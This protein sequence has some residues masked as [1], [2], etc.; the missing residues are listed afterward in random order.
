M[1]KDVEVSMSFKG[2]TV[3]TTLAAIE[4][5]NEKLMATRTGMARIE[6]ISIGK[7]TDKATG[8]NFKFTYSDEVPEGVSRFKEFKYPSI[9]GKLKL[10]VENKSVTFD[11]TGF[12]VTVAVGTGV[13]TAVCK[14]KHSFDTEGLKFLYSNRLCTDDGNEVSFEFI[15]TQREMFEA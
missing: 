14:P 10:K 7:I 3:N 8:C 9:D 1:N 11:L 13:H 15:P 12:E 4:D 6:N 5:Y 2:E